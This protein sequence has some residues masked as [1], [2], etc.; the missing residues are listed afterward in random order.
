MNGMHGSNGVS[1]KLFCCLAAVVCVFAQPKPGPDTLVLVDGEKLIGELQSAAGSKVVFKSDLAG[2]VTVDWSNIKELRSAKKFAVVPK[3][4]ELRKDAA[5][6]IPQ[7]TVELTKEKV[8]VTSGPSSSP[9]SFPAGS[10]ANV[11][12]AQS[13]DRSIHGTSW[14]ESWNGTGAFGLAITESTVRVRDW[15]AAVSLRRSDPSENW[16]QPR[17]RTGLDMVLFYETLQFTGAPT[18]KSQMFNISLVHDYFFRPRVFAF[19]G[20]TWE[21]S[22]AQGLDLVQAYGGGLGMVL[23]KSDTTQM[24]ARAGIGFMDQQFNNPILNKAVVGSRFGE[25]YTHKFAHGLT[26]T[27]Q[28]GFRPAWSYMRAFFGGGS[29]S[30]NYPLYHG[31]GATFGTSGS[32]FNNP[33]PG[34]KKTT[35]QVTVGLNYSIK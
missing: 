14:L 26:L 21:H 5:E 31:L 18:S 4:A 27:E 6:K 16:M 29:A 1:R 10:V 23:I 17:N 20:A 3:E 33:P 15:N 30:L 28:A 9:Q 32:F 25:D 35:L 34:F 7:G 22:Y 19:G 11:V 13:F 8:E 12:D 2:L 24:E